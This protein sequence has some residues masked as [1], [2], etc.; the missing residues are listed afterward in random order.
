M[1]RIFNRCKPVKATIIYRER[2]LHPQAFADAV[3]LNAGALE[4]CGLSEGDTVA[5]LLKNDPWLPLLSMAAAR[6]GL[7][8]VPMNWHLSAEEVAYIV[9]DSGARVLITHKE[10]SEST[11]LVPAEVNQFQVPKWD[12]A[13]EQQSEPE[14]WQHVCS[15]SAPFAGATRSA[16]QSMLYTS[17]TT[18]RPKGVRRPALNPGQIQKVLASMD[19]V[20]AGHAQMRTLCVAPL[21][22]G[23]PNALSLYTLRKGGS[24]VIAD[25]FDAELCLSLI[26]S[27][28][29]THCFMVHTMFVR[30]L[31]LDPAVRNRYK[32]SS[33]ERIVHGAAACA[34]PVKREILDWFGNCVYEYYG[35]TELGP[36][37]VA[38]PEEWEMKPGTVGK[39][40]PTAIVKVVNE[41]R[42]QAA[43]REIG[44]IYARNTAFPDFEYQG[45][46]EQRKS[47]EIE[48]L[49]SCGD[50]GYLDEDGFLFITDR[51]LDM[52]I[53]GGVNIYPAEIEA[54][55]QQIKG[56]RDCAVFGVPDRVF[57]ESVC[58]CIELQ[59]SAK[60]EKDDITAQLR[61]RIG[62]YKLP[63]L[64]YF[65]DRLPRDASG[66]LQKKLLRT[67]YPITTGDKDA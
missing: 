8:A 49:I 53:S 7:T 34:V 33:L 37:T 12:E 26:E 20:Y 6:V 51:K 40:L 65:T 46:S 22:H 10:L 62:S 63:K 43:T 60:L 17:G 61:Q 24:L 35:A 27:H 56:V 48:G 31:E 18:G 15:R 9:E 1:R 28:K 25:K 52:I 39:A 42:E 59:A 32:L 30:L 3:A 2:E 45:A 54:A 36:I 44:E 41:N 55:L 57:G 29:V 14:S 47:I 64:I 5:F 19:S 38:A 50:M 58:A 4:G 13:P 66:K 16:P 67:T 23:A 11:R 21:Y